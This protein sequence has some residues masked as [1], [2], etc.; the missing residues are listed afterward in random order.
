MTAGTSVPA[1]AMAAAAPSEITVFPA[2]TAAYYPSDEIG[3]AGATGF[4]HRHNST[5]SWV[6]TTHADGLTTAIPGLGT[7]AASRFRPTGGDSFSVGPNAPSV[8]TVLNAATQAWRNV[9]ISGSNTKLYGNTLINET[10]PP[11]LVD[12]DTRY[13]I[14]TSGLPD[15]LT[16]FQVLAGD[17]TAGAVVHYGLLDVRTGR[18]TPF[19]APETAPSEVLLTTDGWP[20][21]GPSRPTSTTARA[22]W[23]RGALPLSPTITTWAW[24]AIP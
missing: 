11:R 5:S 14:E 20:S 10:V 13:R 6:W 9:P 3:F 15:G 1:P 8:L 18:F 23:W 2:D 4:L 22:P 17:A 24:P 12:A 19:P 7:S 16:G 21:S